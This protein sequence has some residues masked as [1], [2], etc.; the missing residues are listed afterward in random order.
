MTKS[1]QFITAILAFS[2]LITACEKDPVDP[3]P[4]C[5]IHI[6]NDIVENTTW[7]ASCVYYVDQSVN[8]TNNSTLTIE[9]GTIIKFGQGKKLDVSYYES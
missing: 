8:V 9:P 2:L 3:D 5:D 7:K 6:T 1:I 4:T